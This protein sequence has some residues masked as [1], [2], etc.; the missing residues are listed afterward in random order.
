MV[1][2]IDSRTVK[3]FDDLLAYLARSTEVGQTVT[4]T[5]LRQDRRRPQGDA[6]P[7]AGN[8]PWSGR[9]RSAG[10]AWWVL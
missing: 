2:A 3:T 7:Q 10:N 8:T 5:I 4:L 1:I 6:E 9:P